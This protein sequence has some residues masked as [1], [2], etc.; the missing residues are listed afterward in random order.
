MGALGGVGVLRSD[1]LRSFL[2][3]G[4]PPGLGLKDLQLELEAL[5]LDGEGLGMLLHS[6]GC[7]DFGFE[8]L[9]AAT[10]IR[11]LT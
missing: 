10:E 5:I 8:Q 11:D 2:P 4:I 7:F 9:H 3:L 6:T 1:G